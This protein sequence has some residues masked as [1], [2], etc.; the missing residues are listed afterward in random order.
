[1]VCHFV[2]TSIYIFTNFKHNKIVLLTFGSFF[3]FQIL[4]V[5]SRYNLPLPSDPPPPL[6]LMILAT[7]EPSIH[8]EF[9]SD[10]LTWKYEVANVL[11]TTTIASLLTAFT[12][13]TTSLMGTISIRGFVGV[14]IQIN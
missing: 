10:N 8:I 5:N 12:A 6:L 4:W 9:I 1:M 7:Y 11:S 14:S 13:A 2:L 3:T